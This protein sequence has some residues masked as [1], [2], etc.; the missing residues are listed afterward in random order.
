MKH[1]SAE[2]F[3]VCCV[4]LWS[5]FFFYKN[6]KQLFFF[7][8]TCRFSKIFYTN[9]CVQFICNFCFFTPSNFIVTHAY[10]P[11][12]ATYSAVSYTGKRFL[13]APCQASVKKFHFR[14]N[15]NQPKDNYSS[16]SD[17]YYMYTTLQQT[18]QLQTMLLLST[19]HVQYACKLTIWKNLNGIDFVVVGHLLF[20][21]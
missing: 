18:K 9:K 5:T 13:L 10:E 20:E 1:V 7:S 14:K 12:C 17:D 4:G 15:E 11:H 3:H 21:F 19:A 8:I 6:K 16:P 2:K